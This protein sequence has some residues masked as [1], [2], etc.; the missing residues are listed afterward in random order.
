MIWNKDRVRVLYSFP[1]K[2]GADR[3]CTTA[4]HQVDG[5][6]AAGADVVVMPGAL[7]RPFGP[8]VRVS[9]TLAKGKLR[10]P[11]KILGRMRAL[12]LHDFIVSRR[13]QKLAGQIDIIRTWPLG[14]LRALQT[15][16]RLG[17]P[18]VLERPNAH[19]RFAYEAVRKECE[20]LGLTMPAGDGQ[21][22]Q[23]DVLEKKGAGVSTSRSAHL[24]IRV[25]RP[26]FPRLLICSRT[27][28]AL[29][30]WL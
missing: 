17:I 16:A 19:K 4:W 5:L 30:I 29:P 3:I 28:C 22:C 18:T 25:G 20:R 2:L 14:A 10:I 1:H 27:S 9:P 15:A 11:Y 23:E 6:S 7:Q 21:S 26:H 8:S 13:L 24:S 12:A